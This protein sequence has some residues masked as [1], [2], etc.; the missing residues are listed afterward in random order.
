MVNS[1]MLVGRLATEVELEKDENGEDIA[2]IVLASPRGHKNKDGIYETDF[3]DVELHGTIATH[4]KEYVWKGDI[5]GVKGTLETYI[6]K[7]ED[8][9]R[10]KCYKVVAEKLTWLSS[11]KTDIN[12][13]E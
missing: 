8:E 13:V 1:V 3:I 6:K 10:I 7:E 12:E 11:K 2:N 4:T 5:I 9:T